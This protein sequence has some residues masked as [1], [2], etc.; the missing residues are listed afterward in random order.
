MTCTGGQVKSFQQFSYKGFKQRHLLPFLILFKTNMTGS[1]FQ[2]FRQIKKE[3][4][5]ANFR[6]DLPDHNYTYDANGNLISV[7]DFSDPFY[8]SFP[9]SAYNS[10]TYNADNMPTRI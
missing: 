4:A 2:A 7:P 6:Y 9:R 8:T 1:I 10:I 3:N 5:T